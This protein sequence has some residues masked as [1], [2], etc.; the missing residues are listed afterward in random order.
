MASPLG[1]IPSIPADPR[2]AVGAYI[3]E[4]TALYEVTGIVKAQPFMG[5]VAYRVE[6]ENC[7]NGARI[8]IQAT[9]VREA[10]R[11]V[12]MAPRAVVPDDVEHI[13]WEAA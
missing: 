11:L 7:R 2:L 10:F 4:G 9:K 3:T 6:V 5:T 8:E 13:T 12:R 1:N